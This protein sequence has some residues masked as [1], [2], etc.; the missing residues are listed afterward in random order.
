MISFQIE[1]SIQSQKIGF[2]H[3]DDNSEYIEII[4]GFKKFNSFK[5]SALRHLHL[6]QVYR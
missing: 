1:L 2:F 6:S 3:T 4:A 5:S